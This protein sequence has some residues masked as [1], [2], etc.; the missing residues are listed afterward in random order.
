M[1]EDSAMQEELN[2]AIELSWG[3]ER[4]SLWRV[5]TTFYLPKLDGYHQLD[6][7]SHTLRNFNHEETAAAPARFHLLP[8]SQLQSRTPF[9]TRCVFKVGAHALS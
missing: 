4:V 1:E 2:A 3:G 7:I 8:L 6:R 9:P 5:L